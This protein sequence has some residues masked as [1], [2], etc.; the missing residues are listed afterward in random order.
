[1]VSKF[2]GPVIVTKTLDRGAV[3]KRLQDGT[4]TV[5]NL[6][7]LRVF[8]GQSP[9]EWIKE[10]IFTE[11]KEKIPLMLQFPLKSQK[12]ILLNKI[13]KWANQKLTQKF[14]GILS[15]LKTVN[16]NVQ[17]KLFL[18]SMK[19]P[20]TLTGC[21]TPGHLH[22]GTKNHRSFNFRNEIS[23][24]RGRGWCSLF[25]HL[26]EQGHRLLILFSHF[27]KLRLLS[28]RL[29]SVRPSFSTTSLTLLLDL[30]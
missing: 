24:Q 10:L 2:N 18:F 9:L 20:A 23:G 15:Y 3:V 4:E 19:F 27:S 17:G 16:Q 25:H 22:N 12:S 6:D 26:F 21:P 1:M 7:W 13:M 11:K 30:R 29:L 5:A 28:H 8:K 14:L